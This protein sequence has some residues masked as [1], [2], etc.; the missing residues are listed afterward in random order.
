M[1]YQ[2]TTCSLNSVFSSNI[3]LNCCRVNSSTEIS[4]RAT[5]VSESSILKPQVW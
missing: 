4:V 5:V 1:E 3:W 2:L